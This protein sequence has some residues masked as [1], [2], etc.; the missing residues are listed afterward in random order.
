MERCSIPPAQLRENNRKWVKRA[1]KQM[2]ARRKRE[3]K[4][5][6]H[7]AKKEK[8][9]TAMQRAIRKINKLPQP[10]KQWSEASFYTRFNFR[11]LCIRA[12]K[13]KATTGA[14]FTI[15][16]VSRADFENIFGR[17]ELQRDDYLL[18]EKSRGRR[19]SCSTSLGV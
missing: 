1:G 12:C 14:T 10:E 9:M 6:R 15:E 18:N 2:Q 3:K 11:K 4:K 5:E 19:I 16:G 7:K 13:L 8:N 17:C